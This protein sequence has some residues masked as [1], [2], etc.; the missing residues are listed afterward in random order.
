MAT[1]TYSV[2][3]QRP[4]PRGWQDCLDH[5]ATRFAVRRHERRGKYRITRFVCAYSTKAAAIDY[6]RQLQRLAKPKPR[7]P[8][9]G[10]RFL[11]TGRNI[12]ARSL[13]YDQFHAGAKPHNREK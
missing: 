12:I 10:Q 11:R 3:P 5:E 2:Q 1:V 7:L 6:Q 13:S 4:S 8:A 9:V